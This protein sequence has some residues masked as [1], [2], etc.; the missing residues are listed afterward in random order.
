MKYNLLYTLNDIISFKSNNDFLIYKNKSKQIIVNNE[1]LFDD[2]YDDIHINNDFLMFNKQGRAIVYNLKNKNEKIKKYFE[3]LASTN[4]LNQSIILIDENQ[5]LYL[6]SL[7]F[8]YIYQL[9][10]HEYNWG[11]L[12][13]FKDFIIIGEKNVIKGYSNDSMNLWQYDLSALGTWKD[14]TDTEQRYELK[15][16]I[17]VIDTSLFIKLNANEI[18]VL[19]I[20]SGNVS[21]R[22]RFIDYFEGETCIER[23]SPEIPF[24]QTRYIINQDKSIIQGL[25]LDLYYE[26]SFINGKLYTNVFGL[27]KSMKSGTSILVISAKRMYCSMT[28]CISWLTSRAG[29]AY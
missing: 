10:I 18:L 23:S 5:L 3:I 24:F 11:K 4:I 15:D 16:F 21:D 1:K 29:L 17:G 22:L 28:S 13:L 20:N 27:K 8:N 25:F 9:K 7:D 2:V 12:L 19:D 14:S 6:S 26:I